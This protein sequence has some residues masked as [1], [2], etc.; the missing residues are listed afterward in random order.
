[1]SHD[2][3]KTKKVELR[4]VEN[5]WT[6][7]VARGEGID[8]DTATEELFRKFQ[9]NEIMKREIERCEQYAVHVHVHGCILYIKLISFDKFYFH[10]HYSFPLL[11][12]SP[13]PLSPSP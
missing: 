13:L 11:L 7:P 3:S 8:T 4:K 2:L 1:M 10:V 9:V 5:C 12:P 6:R